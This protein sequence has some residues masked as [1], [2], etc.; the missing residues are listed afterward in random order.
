MA[1]RYL[2]CAPVVSF[3]GLGLNIINNS[4]FSIMVVLARSR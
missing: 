3:I 4:T 2:L 1:E